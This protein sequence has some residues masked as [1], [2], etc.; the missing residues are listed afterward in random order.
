VLCSEAVSVPVKSHTSTFGGNPLA[1]A[2]ALASLEVIEKQGLVQKAG[3]LGNYFMEGL[4]AIRSDKI[5]EVRGLGLMIGIELKEK[6]GPYV[7][8]LMEKG[9]IVLLAG[10]NVIR[11]LPPLVITKEEIDQALKALRDTLSGE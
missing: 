2:A 11:L 3:T 5:R 7:Q 6:A 4:K 1:C 9:I 8:A 10:A